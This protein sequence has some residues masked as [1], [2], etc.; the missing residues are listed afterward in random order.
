MRSKEILYI[1]VI[2]P[3]VVKESELPGA[4][5]F[6]PCTDA[7]PLVALCQPA[8]EMAMAN[9][10]FVGLSQT[11]SVSPPPPPVLVPAA[12]AAAA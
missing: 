3:A 2:R 9:N 12:A 10:D 7:P 1:G 4:S 6:V 8:V 5:S 11:N